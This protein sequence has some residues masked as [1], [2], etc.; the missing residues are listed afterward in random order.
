MREALVIESLNDKRAEIHGRTAACEAQIA[1]ARNDLTHVNA[2]I[3]L[4]AE[5]E[6]QRARYMV[7]Q[8]FFKNGETADICVRHLGFMAR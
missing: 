4:F 1:Q 3:R 6:Y 2:T 7:C 5:P 8:G